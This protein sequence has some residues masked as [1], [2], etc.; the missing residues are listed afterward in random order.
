[1]TVGQRIAQ[2]RK[3]LGLS[4]EGLGDK[5]GVSRQAIYKWESDASLPEVEKLVAL[6]RIF[7]V[8]VGWLLGE[9]EHPAG[10]ADGQ[11]A[12]LTEAQIKMVQEIADRYLAAQTARMEQPPQPPARRRWPLIAG[13]A[14]A[15]V[16]AAL[17][18]NLFSQ[19]NRVS[20]DY[21]NL[22]STISNVSSNVNSQIGS[23]TSRVEEILKAQNS[24]TASYNAEF[25]SS[26][27]GA[28]TASFALEAVPKTYVEGMEAVFL[29]DC[30]D[31]PLEF[32]GVLGEGQSFSAQVT[33]PLTDSITLSV[34]FVNGERR[35]T[36][37]LDVF[38]YLLSDTYPYVSCDG[39]DLWGSTG[40]DGVLRNSRYTF[41]TVDEAFTGGPC[42]KIADIQVGLFRDQKLVAR[43]TPCEQPDSYKGD[44]ENARFFEG[45]ETITLE[46]GYTYCMAALV[47]DEYG[48]QWV[49]HGTPAVYD[50]EEEFVEY[51]DIAEDYSSDPADWDFTVG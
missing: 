20:Q 21:G 36:Q 37:M 32:P 18:L 11:S 46:P 19:L 38:T 10:Q 27:P 30:G 26:D 8:P 7:S 5:L 9:E 45:P 47:T 14:A 31:G 40:K 34:V 51:A 2:K 35:E 44:W 15:L 13:G 42:T 39:S 4:Q 6:S 41:I 50:P 43:Y 24:L 1:M 22:Q 49:V 16:A 29:A 33:V 48:R 23:I 17:F 3:E 12:E 25:L 28:G